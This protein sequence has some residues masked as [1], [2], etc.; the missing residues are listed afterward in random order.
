[1]G[2]KKSNTKSVKVIMHCQ[3]TTSVLRGA[4]V[5]PSLAPLV[6]LK[7]E[8]GF[9]FSKMSIMPPTLYTTWYLATKFLCTP[10]QVMQCKLS[11]W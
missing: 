5:P 6:L 1:M 11:H 8:N 9:M 2:D 4:I 10:L 7:N 3:L